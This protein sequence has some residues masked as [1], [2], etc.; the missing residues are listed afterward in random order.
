MNTPLHVR[1]MT[2]Q[3]LA[4]AHWLRGEVGWNQTLDDWKR[5]LELEPDGCFLAEWSGAPVGTATTITYA[6]DLAWIGMVL[7]RPEYRGRGIARRLLSACITRLQDLGIRCIKLDATPAGRPVYSRLGFRDE[8]TLPR[9]EGGL[10]KPL[11][12]APAPCIRIWQESDPART[13]AC[14][15]AAFGVTRQRLVRV[16]ASQ[17]RRGVV[18]QDQLGR[19]LGFGHLRNGSRALYLGPVVAEAADI[20]IRLV[21]ALV[22]QT[23][24]ETLFWDIP[25]PN[26]A[27]ADWAAEHGFTVQRALTRM[28]LGENLVPGDTCR[29]FA[30]ARP[31][32]G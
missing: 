23:E 29:Q 9:W 3:D 28:Y 21:E 32:S 17:S 18:F 12:I 25:Q 14:D 15:V 13:A 22:A 26:A 24:G 19:P 10:S 2:V 6:Q 27:A 5:F 30:L 20:G 11:S 8:G 31:E 7:V 4:F 16:L 1:N